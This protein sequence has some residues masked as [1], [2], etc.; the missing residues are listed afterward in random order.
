ML[1]DRQTNMTKMVSHWSL[2]W[3]NCAEGDGRLDGVMGMPCNELGKTS[4]V[5]ALKQKLSH[6]KTL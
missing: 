6:M 5:E 4:N 2:L 3:G 1:E